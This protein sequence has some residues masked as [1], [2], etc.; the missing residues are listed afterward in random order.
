LFFPTTELVFAV[1]EIGLRARKNDPEASADWQ[2][3][4]LRRPPVISR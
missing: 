3:D 2:G 1:E 4:D